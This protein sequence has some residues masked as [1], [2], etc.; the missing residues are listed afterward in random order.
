VPLE[1]KLRYSIFSFTTLS[2]NSDYEYSLEWYS[3]RS[4][5]VTHAKKIYVEVDV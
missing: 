5:Y 2:L 4:L 1:F 3:K